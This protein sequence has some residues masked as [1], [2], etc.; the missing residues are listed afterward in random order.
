VKSSSY[1][2]TFC[3]ARYVMRCDRQVCPDLQLDQQEEW[4]KPCYQD[5]KSWNDVVGI[6]LEHRDPDKKV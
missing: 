1:E 3:D 6:L 5:M 2:E 4:T